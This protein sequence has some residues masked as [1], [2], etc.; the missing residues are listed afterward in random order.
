[1]YV[2]PHGFPA[3][4]WPTLPAAAQPTTVS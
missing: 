4:C 2:S 3:C 1:V